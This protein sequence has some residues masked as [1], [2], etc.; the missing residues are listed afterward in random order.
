M[1]YL[2]NIEAY[3]CE[4]CKYAWP[5]SNGIEFCKGCF[6]EDI[7]LGDLQ[8]FGELGYEIFSFGKREW[9]FFLSLGGYG[10]ESCQVGWTRKWGERCPNC[11]ELQVR[12]RTYAVISNDSGDEDICFHSAESK[13]QAFGYFPP[14]SLLVPLAGRWCDFCPE[15]YWFGGDKCPTCDYEY[16]DRIALHDNSEREDLR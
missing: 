11:D 10:H 12:R 5:E 6:T 7:I 8:S 9:N 15:T 3:G 16:T 2:G 14:G 13:E 4:S 1:S